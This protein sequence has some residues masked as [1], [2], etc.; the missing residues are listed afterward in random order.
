[1]PKNTTST[2]TNFSWQIFFP[3]FN[4]DEHFRP[5]PISVAAV[6]AVSV[7]FVCLFHIQFYF[8]CITNMNHISLD[9]LFMVWLLGLLCLYYLSIGT[10]VYTC[11]RHLCC[12][13]ARIR[14]CVRFP[15]SNRYRC[16]SSPKCWLYCTLD[17]IQFIPVNAMP[18][19]VAYVMCTSRCT[20]SYIR[21]A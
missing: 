12:C 21:S 9:H 10:N 18:A 19:R 14:F 4:G 20:Q 11:S 17:S 3:H 8:A 16:A 13:S 2:E 1:M 7:L 15:I 5:L 6:V